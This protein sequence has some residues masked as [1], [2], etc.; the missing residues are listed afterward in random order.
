MMMFHEMRKRL[1]SGTSA[2]VIVLVF[3]GAE[4]CHA[5]F[6]YT[7]STKITGGALVG[8]TKSLGVFSKDARQAMAPQISSTMVKGNVMRREQADGSVSI[9]DLD[10]RRFITIDQAKKT[11][12]VMTFD[13][14]KAAMQQA[15]ARVKDQQAA[16]VAQH[17][18]A[19]NVKLTPKIH[20]EETGATR[21]I[22]NLPTSEVKWR[23]DMEV[24]S[25][26]PK[27]Q[28][29]N[30]SATMTLTS[31]SWMAGSIPGYDELRQFYLRLAKELDWLP[32]TMG[33][34]AMN[35][36]MGPAMEEF[37]KNAIKLKGMPL[38]TTMSFIM[39]ATGAPTPG[40]AQSGQ[41]SQTAAPA[42][43]TLQRHRAGI[44]ILSRPCRRAQKTPSPKGWGECSEA[45][46]RKNSSRRRPAQMH[47]RTR[48]EVWGPGLRSHRR[49]A[50]R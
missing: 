45:S 10:G 17:P 28:Q 49:P 33:M 36:Q 50:T 6:K 23:L 20:S 15:Q 30:Q 43:N 18:E 47:P 32:G 29:Q 42:S 1:F 22:L 35:S 19:A 16:A 34:S 7:E 11:Y 3:A 5:D 41:A 48:L 14:F 9:I 31:D 44:R 37:R 26:D 39:S 27:V 12:S 38:L 13:D 4:V 21:T 2:T 24:Q 25:T 40:A 8:L 46:R